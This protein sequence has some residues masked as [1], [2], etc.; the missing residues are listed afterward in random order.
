[1]D[2][3][4]KI[5]LSLNEKIRCLEEIVARLKKILYVYDKSL[6]P[7]STYNYRVYCG[8]IAMY[9]SSSNI[10][11]NGEL[12]SIIININ[13]IL[14]NQLNKGQIKKLVFDSINF[15]EYLLAKYKEEQ[16]TI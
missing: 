5:V 10:L 16:E 9:V 14:N 12:V 4:F 7:D 13:S 15:S 1:M 3:N 11:F 6:E 2:E 8:G